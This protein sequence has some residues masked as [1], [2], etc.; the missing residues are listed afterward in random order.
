[1][2]K[3]K[4]L[5]CFRDSRFR[6]GGGATVGIDPETAA[7]AV[8]SLR[9]WWNQ[10]GRQ[11]YPQAKHLLISADG[12]ASNGSHV[13]LWK[14][15]LQQLADE[16]GLSITVC[17]FPAGT[18][19]WTKMEPRLFAWIS[20]NQN[21]QGKPLISSAI[22]LKVIT[23]ATTGADLSV[24][25]QLDTKSYPPGREVSDEEMATLSLVPDPSM[26][27]GTSPSCLVLSQLETLFLDNTI[28]Y[29]LQ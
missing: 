28:I 21:W 7:F 16:T 8:E 27:D 23:A 9:R 3:R 13:R 17:Y 26:A 1:M 25:C 5:L 10:V 2:P 19:K 11:Q 24:Q 20:Q 29:T 15:E 6:T 18:S 12:G 14:W 4:E 22:I